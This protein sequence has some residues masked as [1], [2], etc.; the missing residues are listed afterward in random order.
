MARGVGWR[1]ASEVSVEVVKGCLQA[2]NAAAVAHTPCLRSL[3]L[4][5]LCRSACVIYPHIF[6][7][8]LTP[9]DKRHPLLSAAA[10]QPLMDVI[11]R[12]AKNT[13]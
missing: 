11:L 6:S 12:R 2:E 4:G 3:F 9:V 1:N 10:T 7:G 8:F 5:R 13:L